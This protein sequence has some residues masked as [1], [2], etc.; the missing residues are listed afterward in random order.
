MQAYTITPKGRKTELEEC[1]TMYEVVMVYV[2]VLS[3]DLY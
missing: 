2:K 3:E 1:Q